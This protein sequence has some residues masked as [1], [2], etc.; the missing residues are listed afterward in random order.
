MTRPT[1]ASNQDFVVFVDVIQATIAWDKSGY[2][3]T[4]LNELYPHAFPDGTVRL[5]SLD[6]KLLYHNTLG[7]RRPS[8]RIGLPSCS[9]MCLLV[10]LISPSE[11]PQHTS[12]YVWPQEHGML[13]HTDNNIF[14]L[15]RLQHPSPPPKKPAN[16]YDH[17]L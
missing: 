8:E 17:D 11:Q 14:S 6:S 3:F 5:L 13:F 15:S 7:V 1:E 12:N 10:G 9:K 4:V 16:N 2:L